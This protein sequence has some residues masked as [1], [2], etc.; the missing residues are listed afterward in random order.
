MYE[1]TPYP[2][3]GEVC[4]KSIVEE[5][6]MRA[7]SEIKTQNAPKTEGESKVLEAPKVAA[8]QTDTELD[9]VLKELQTVIAVIGIGG[10]VLILSRG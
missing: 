2:G 4:M 1:N 5:A 6:M 7:E 8:P 9:Q 10:G 3:I